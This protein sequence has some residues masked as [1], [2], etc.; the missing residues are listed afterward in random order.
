MN[1]CKP[2]YNVYKCT[3]LFA[4]SKIIVPY[5]F[6]KNILCKS[7]RGIT[8]EE[9]HLFFLINQNAMRIFLTGHIL[10]I[11]N[12]VRNVFLMVKTV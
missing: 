7:F 1:K 2:K 4:Q 9:Q 12:S 5:I 10:N 11:P 3:F 8:Y 6:K